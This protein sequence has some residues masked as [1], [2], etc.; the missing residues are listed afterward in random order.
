MQSGP[1][2]KMSDDHRE[3]ISVYARIR[4]PS[5][6]HVDG[7]VN[8]VE[9]KPDRVH[10]KSTQLKADLEFSLDH[11]FDSAATQSELYAH[12]GARLVARVVDGY[13]ATILAYGQTG[14]GKTF[15]M[16]GGEE[17]LAKVA[18]AGQ[19]AAIDEGLGLVPR[20]CM[21]LFANLPKGHTVAFSYVEVYNDTVLDLLGTKGRPIA[22]REV[23]R[24]H[25]EPEGLTRSA[26]GG[27][28]DVMRCVAEGDGRRV[29]AAMAMNPRSSRGH[30]ILALDTYAPSGAHHGRLTLVDLAGMESS[31]KSAAVDGASN[32]KER[33][34]EAK[35]I[36][37]SLLALEGVIAALASKAAHRIPF[38]DSK[39]T[40]LLQS[41]LGGNCVAA[42]VVT[43]RSE[44]ANM[45]ETI[46]SLRLAQR[47]KA[48][49]ALVV[50]NE[51]ARVSGGSAVGKRLASELELAKGALADFEEQLAAS[52]ST[53]AQ[54]ANQARTRRDRTLYIY[55]L[56]PARRPRSAP[57][58]RALI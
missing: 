18:S 49:E 22:L 44:K 10:A 23:S 20:A 16:L 43:L 13:N 6:G 51:V 12:V 58:A 45:D 31:K 19:S 55:G 38:R 56:G 17:A 29:V 25:I 26:V 21:Q 24:N 15:T 35:R 57:Y 50:K 14:S 39:L 7:D 46:A 32:T 41:S 27:V 53:N 54:L 3:R 5:D 1:T 8:V 52:H 47:A 48:V 42:F 30:G 33:R 11:A 28:A 34:E 40:R 2:C 9:G 4:Q 37:I 36:N